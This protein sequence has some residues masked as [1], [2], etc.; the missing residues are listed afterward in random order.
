MSE[1]LQTY[2]YTL[3]LAPVIVAVIFLVVMLFLDWMKGNFNTGH[4]KL[5]KGCTV[6]NHKDC[7]L[8][9]S[10]REFYWC[11]CPCH[12]LQTNYETR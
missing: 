3:I 2:T 12:K 8:F 5:K 9:T 6:S 1:E 10:D 11:D 7:E 4:K